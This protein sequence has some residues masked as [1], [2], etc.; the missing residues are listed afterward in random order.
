METN[1][2]QQAGQVLAAM[3]TRFSAFP[4][5]DVN[6]APFAGSWTPAQVVQHILL[7]LDGCLAL[8][9]GP[10]AATGRNPEQHVQELRDI[11]LNFEEKY[12]SPPDIVPEEKIYDKT[13]L[14]RQLDDLRRNLETA[15]SSHDLTRTCTT[16]E[17]PTV[18]Y[19]TGIEVANFAVV[20]TQRHI[21]QLEEMQ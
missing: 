2:S 20:H 16:F 12:Q 8:L 21:H 7:S 5:P 17:F 1:L 9:N 10:T 18:G 13:A 3:S 6:I 14:S 15:I 4:E 19:L 11:F